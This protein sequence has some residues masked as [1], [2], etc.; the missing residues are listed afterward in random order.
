MQ[1]SG[2]AKTDL[3][4]QCFAILVFDSGSRRGNRSGPMSVK[5]FMMRSARTLSV[6][7]ATTFTLAT[8]LAACDQGP[9]GS[10]PTT[11]TPQADL[12]GHPPMAISRRLLARRDAAHL[13][14]L[15][16]LPSGSRRLANEPRGDHHLLSSPG[17]TTGD[18]NLVD[19]HGFFV[20]AASPPSVETYLRS[21]V[22]TGAVSDGFGTASVRGVADE[23]F[24]DDRWPPV[25]T[26]L[27]TRTLVI[28]IA[29][30]PNHRS[31]IRVDAQVTWL[32]AKPAGDLIPAGAKSLTAVLSHGL[33]PG[34]RGHKPVTT[35]DPAKIAAVRAFINQLGVLSPGVRFCPADFGQYLTISFRKSAHAR[36]FAF[37]VVDV[38][39]CEVAQVHQFGRLIHPSLAGQGLVSFVEQELGF[40]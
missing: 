5:L 11:A 35:T 1:T 25:K 10:P 36:R 13:L 38:G 22:P 27:D 3:E 31:G 39:G 33:N 14:R 15:V 7:L 9:S 19:V 6:L 17:Q 29:A 37:V 24:V 2:L 16:R 8:G 40:R 30:L 28:S 4:S 32:R 21:Y 18:P 26:V 20:V 34:E 12:T 23:W